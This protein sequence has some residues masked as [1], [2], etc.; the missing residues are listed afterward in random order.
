[1]QIPLSKGIQIFG[2]LSAGNLFFFSI[3]CKKEV[4]GQVLSK[5]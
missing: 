1:M 3:R 2:P 4:V 5:S